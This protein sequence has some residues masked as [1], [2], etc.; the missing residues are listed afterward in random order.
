MKV[1]ESW[2]RTQNVYFDERNNF[3]GTTFVIPLFFKI[4]IG[5]PIKKNLL[6]LPKDIASVGQPSPQVKLTMA[7]LTK[8]RDACHAR[9]AIAKK[10]L[11]NRIYWSPRMFVYI[12]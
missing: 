5:T 1:V 12:V 6:K 10:D 11:W 8:L 4:I 7:A 3:T 2:D 9:S